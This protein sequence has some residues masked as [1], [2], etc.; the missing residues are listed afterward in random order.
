MHEPDAH[1][2]QGRRVLVVEDDF[3]IA[4]ELQHM[5]ES[6]GSH[7]VGPASTVADALQLISDCLVELAVLDVNL[8]G[9]K[10]YPIAD[11]LRVRGIPFVFATGYDRSAL[12]S[13][14]ADAPRCEKPIDLGKMARLLDGDR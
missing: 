8:G 9:E 11:V 14:Y 7:V 13:E 5:L 3:M 2:L 4:D 6:L 10:A 1:P 12:P